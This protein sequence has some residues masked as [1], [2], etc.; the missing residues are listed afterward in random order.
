[1]STFFGGGTVPTKTT[2][3][4]IDAPRQSAGAQRNPASATARVRANRFPLMQYP[5][6]SLTQM[7]A[8]AGSQSPRRGETAANLDTIESSLTRRSGQGSRPCSLFDVK[9]IRILLASRYQAIKRFLVVSLRRGAH[10]HRIGAVTLGDVSL[11]Q[12]LVADR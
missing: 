1:M 7:I 3:P 11:R 5:W 8:T 6:L 9:T 2:L 10:R 4:L 12:H